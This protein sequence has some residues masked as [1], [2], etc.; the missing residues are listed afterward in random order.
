LIYYA[1]KPFMSPPSSTP[2][3]QFIAF[4]STPDLVFM[5]IA[6][7]CGILL[8]DSDCSPANLISLIRAKEAAQALL[9]EAI[10]KEATRVAAIEVASPNAQAQGDPT[11]VAG[12][13]SQAPQ[14]EILGEANPAAA[15]SVAP[16][17]STKKRGSCP[18]PL[19]R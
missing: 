1:A 18:I 19:C 3:A 2:N 4:S 17:G 16:L 9:A 12:A 14:V 10:K 7:D 5:G 11:S 8:G 6:E 15:I 13:P